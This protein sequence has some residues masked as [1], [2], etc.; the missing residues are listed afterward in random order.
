MKPR[1]R[2]RCTALGLATGV[3]ATALL[4]GAVT[5][6]NAG[7]FRQPSPPHNPAVTA[8]IQADD[9]HLGSEIR[10]HENAGRAVALPAG[11]TAG[12]DVSGYQGNVDWAVAAGN[13]A[14][15]AYVK[16]TEGTYYTNP[17][18]GQQFNGSHNAGIIRG[19][20]HFARP[21]LTSGAAQADYFI[22]NGGG[23]SPDGTTLPGTLDI[24]WDPYGAACY[25]LGQAAMV[26]W[27][28]SF[29]TEYHA[30]TRRWPA[31]YTATSWWSQCTGGLGDFSAND[32]LWLVSFSSSAGPK[33]YK[34]SAQR[35]WQY[36]DSGIFPGDQDF[37]NGDITQVRALAV[38]C[39]PVTVHNPGRPPVERIAILPTTQPTCTNN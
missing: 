23:W 36:A 24:E 16:A 8:W 7:Q 14:K 11:S 33:P 27:I 5:T 19:A 29:A 38:G 13:G 25:G 17:Y 31:I 32:P 18:F 15:F 4:L 10:K 35:I 34:W 26:D 21:D 2:G 37:F 28:H 3:A 6:A 20:Y 1:H 22:T 12:M 9:H 39:P 30:R